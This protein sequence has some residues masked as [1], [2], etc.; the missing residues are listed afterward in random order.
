MG[1]VVPKGG[2]CRDDVR[3]VHFWDVDFSMPHMPHL[4]AFSTGALVWSAESRLLHTD[5]VSAAGYP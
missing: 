4:M 3:D 5:R 1:E 2:F